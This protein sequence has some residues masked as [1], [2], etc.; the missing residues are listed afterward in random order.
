[1][2]PPRDA[3]GVVVPP[4][5]GSPLHGLYQSLRAELGAREG[6][7]DGGE[8]HAATASSLVV[9]GYA[10][11]LLSLG[12][13]YQHGKDGHPRNPDEAARCYAKAGRLAGRIGRR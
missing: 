2:L 1:M 12:W 6:A 9:L 13:R 10:N 8:A 4:A 3:N 5:A 7:A 11:A